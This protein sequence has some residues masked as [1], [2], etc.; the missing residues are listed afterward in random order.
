MQLQ[1]EICWLI[2]KA[3]IMKVK[4]HVKSQ[5]TRLMEM[6][7]RRLAGTKESSP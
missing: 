7:N 2:F 6:R 1:R 5:R 4:Y 3:K